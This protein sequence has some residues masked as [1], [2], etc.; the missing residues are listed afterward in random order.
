MALSSS[1]CAT[2][3]SI[4][5]PSVCLRGQHRHHP[6][7]L[8]WCADTSCAS[9]FFARPSCVCFSH[10]RGNL[11]FGSRCMLL[12][13][14]GG[15][16]VRTLLHV[17]RQTEALHPCKGATCFF[18]RFC[19]HRRLLVV[20]I[21]CDAPAQL[22]GAPLCGLSLHACTGWGNNWP[23]GDVWRCRLRQSGAS[24]G[25]F[26]CNR[27]DQQMHY[28]VLTSASIMF[29]ASCMLLPGF[30]CALAALF[31]Q[32]ACSLGAVPPLSIAQMSRLPLSDR[33]ARLK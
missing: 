9:L 14:T 7:L 5:L 27:W 26:G 4:W 24:A 30:W 16:R 11:W 28:V 33:L 19:G 15:G 18:D 31:G 1:I 29:H 21:S 2:I 25:L 6:V 12:C 23:I 10:T 17:S 20:A 13:S 8:A 22:M 3:N 32:L